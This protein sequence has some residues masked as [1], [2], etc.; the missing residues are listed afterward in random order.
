MLTI[1]KIKLHNFKRFRELMLDVNPDI[2]ILI[3]DNESGK[4]TILQAIDLVAR[5]SRTR[6]ENIGLDRLFNVEAM[7]MFM[8]SARNLNDIPELY[9]E[10]YFDN[11]PDIELEGMNNSLNVNCSGI[12]LR[13]FLNDNY[14]QIVSQILQDPNASFPL[15]F[16]SIAF[17]TFAGESFNGY[18]KK[19]KS[20]FIDNSTIG[21]PH[22]M[23]EYVNDIFR[24]QLSEQQRINVR[25]EY[26]DS[27]IQF[28]TNTLS[29]YNIQIAPYSFAIKESSEDNIETDIT[30]VE[31]NIPLENKGTGTQ[32]FIKTKLSLNRVANSIDVVL[33]EEPE[34]HLSYMKMLEL[35]S[36]IRNAQNR[37]LF[38]STHSDL[39]A[40]RLNL[41]KC[42]L[43]NSTSNDVCNLTSLNDDTADFFMKAPDNNMLQ[44][45][46]SKKTILVEGDAEFILMEVLYKRTLTKELSASNIG[47]IAVDGKCFKRYLEISKILGNKVAVL[48]DNDKNYIDNI[49]NNYSDYTQNQFSNI[50]IFSDCDNTRYTFEVCLYNDNQEICD[51]EFQT[52]LRRLN[53][54]EYMLKNKA[55]AAYVLMK[56]RADTIT[57]PQYIQDACV[58]IDA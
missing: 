29:Q 9:I 18:T 42:I 10:L 8:N 50:Q 47:V 30:L 25:H 16:Y 34:N 44:F 52:P 51:A 39:I 19:I 56:N 4:S 58:W 26:K 15:E 41:K 27:K 48:T 35:I 2:N 22:A 36:L 40:T 57:V 5:G 12:R 14:T 17:D 28:Q 3:G 20:L 49:T 7:D 21:N 45:V 6:I 55:E 1:T 53:T 24:S 43:F 13:C 33:I 37:Q 38:I 31:N 46:L 11:Q 23:R 32:C 54:L